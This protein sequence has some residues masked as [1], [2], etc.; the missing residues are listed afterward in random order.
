MEIQEEIVEQVI[1]QKKR[2]SSKSRSSKCATTAGTRHLRYRYNRN[3]RELATSSRMFSTRSSL[4]VEEEFVDFVE[5]E[6]DC[7]HQFGR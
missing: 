6:F 3:F 1:K 4:F 7:C 5:E 2:R